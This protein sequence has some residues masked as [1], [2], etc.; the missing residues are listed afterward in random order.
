MDPLSELCKRIKAPAGSGIAVLWP[1]MRLALAV[2]DYQAHFPDTGLSDDL[3]RQALL[4]LARAAANDPAQMSLLTPD[5]WSALAEI[6]VLPP[7]TDNADNKTR[8]LV[9]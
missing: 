7:D 8:G 6:G 5:H 1:G 2:Q 4:D 9:L 3:I